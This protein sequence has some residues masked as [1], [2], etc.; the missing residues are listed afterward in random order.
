MRSIAL[1]WA[2]LIQAISGFSQQGLLYPAYDYSSF[3]SMPGKSFADGPLPLYQPA[4]KFA[5]PGFRM[6]VSHQQKVIG[7]GLGYR[8]MAV[9]YGTRKELW[10]LGLQSQG[11]PDL[12]QNQLG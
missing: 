12:K 11:N 8:Q 4:L 10:G 6:S 3:L 2:C 1:V 9:S 5:D 7:S